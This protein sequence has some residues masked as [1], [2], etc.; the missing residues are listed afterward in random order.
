MIYLTKD[1]WNK[2]IF[3]KISDSNYFNIELKNI[4]K[5][6]SLM[7]FINSKIKFS[8]QIIL[9][10]SMI[11]FHKYYLQKNLNLKNISSIDKLILCGSCIFIST[12]ATNNLISINSL[13]KI[14]K[15]IINIKLSNITLNE[16]SIK[17][18][19]IQSEYAI[20]ESISFDLNID[21]P[22]KF[23]LQLK[24]YFNKKINISSELLIKSSCQFIND[25]FH[26]PFCLF[27]SPNTIAIACIKLM[28]E[29]YKLYDINLDEIILKSEYKIEKND[30]DVCFY[31]MEKFYIKNNEKNVN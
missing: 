6:Y 15:E 19:L 27:Y 26:F 18:L 22:Y 14:I 17:N 11:F 28:I 12:K 23:I 30:V 5:I 20:L 3:P 10:T 25:S 24:D 16:D 7:S 31:L 9:S 4:K 8:N 21:L 13:I 29:K 1:D 2:F